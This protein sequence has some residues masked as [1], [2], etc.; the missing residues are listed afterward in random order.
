M[1]AKSVKSTAAKPKKAKATKK[2][3]KTVKAPGTSVTRKKRPAKASAKLPP[4]FTLEPKNR[5]A[6]P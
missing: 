4:S 3:A 1:P 6:L 2:T 5:R